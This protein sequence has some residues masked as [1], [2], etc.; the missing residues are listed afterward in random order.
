MNH[1]TKVV[2][3]HD[4]NYLHVVCEG[5]VLTNLVAN[6]H[7]DIYRLN[8]FKMVSDGQ[9]VSTS[10]KKVTI[11]G[12]KPVS[13]HRLICETFHGSPP[14]EEENIVNHIDGCYWNNA[15]SNLEW[16]SYSGNSIHAYE[17]GLREDNRKVKIKN[18]VENT[19]TEYYSL[20]NA[21]SALG[22]NNALMFHWLNK[23]SARAIQQGKYV[24]AYSDEEY[25]EY[26]IKDVGKRNAFEIRPVLEKN[27]LTGE[28]TYFESNVAVIQYRKIP[29]KVATFRARMGRKDRKNN[30][31][32]EYGDYHYSYLPDDFDVNTVELIRH[33]RK[34]KVLDEPIKRAKPITVTNLITSSSKDYPSTQ[35][36]ADEIGI[37]KNTIQKAMWTNDGKFR[38]YLIT[39][40]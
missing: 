6:A 30:D 7:G 17:T 26:D 33:A 8:P 19:E 21:A 16:T 9:Y 31:G 29:L 10:R 35:A 25:P 12:R 11:T 28:L 15:A 2:Y 27:K 14:S 1:E 22:I 24:V 13:A 32:T 23:R 20:S 37:K 5:E 34:K 18:L 36:F 3:E 38:E 40:H 4:S 39:Y